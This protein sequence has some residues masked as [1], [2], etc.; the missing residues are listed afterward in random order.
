MT[1]FYRDN[2]N[3]QL[4]EHMYGFGGRRLKIRDVCMDLEPCF[5][6]QNLLRLL[7]T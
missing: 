4:F 6:V 3:E 7:F 2:K 1:A 5:K